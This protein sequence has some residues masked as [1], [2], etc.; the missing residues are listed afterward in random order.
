MPTERT[1]PASRN[2]CSRSTTEEPH[3][4]RNLLIRTQSLRTNQIFSAPPSDEVFASK[5]IIKKILPVF[6]KENFSCSNSS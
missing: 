5:T 3:E 6:V 2:H 1:H 4:E